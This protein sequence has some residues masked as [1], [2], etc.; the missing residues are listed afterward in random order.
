MA[1]AARHAADTSSAAWLRPLHE[2]LHLQL[3]TTQCVNTVVTQM[4]IAY[5]QL[6]AKVHTYCVMSQ[7]S[8]SSM[9]SALAVDYTGTG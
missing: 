7:A 3:Q 4:G 8:M 9:Q 2:W 6:R 5:F 1:V